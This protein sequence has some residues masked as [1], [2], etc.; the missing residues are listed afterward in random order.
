MKKLVLISLRYKFCRNSCFSYL[1]NKPVVIHVIIVPSFKDW[2]NFCIIHVHGK[3]PH[4]MLL[5]SI[6]VEDVKTFEEIFNNLGP[7]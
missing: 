3:T 7:M 4:S 1:R 2:I 5:L 6:Y